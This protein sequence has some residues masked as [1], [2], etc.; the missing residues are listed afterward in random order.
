ME[1]SLSRALNNPA[2]HPSSVAMP[3]PPSNQI[4][5]MQ[6]EQGRGGRCR[7]TDGRLFLSRSALGGGNGARAAARQTVRDNK[8]TAAQ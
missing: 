1:L 8:K 4:A 5:I 3:T 2:L 6:P 7:R